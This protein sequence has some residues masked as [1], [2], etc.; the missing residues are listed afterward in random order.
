M[1]SKRKRQSGHEGRK[2]KAQKQ[3]QAA[4]GQCMQLTQLFKNRENAQSESFAIVDLLRCIDENGDRDADTEELRMSGK[5]IAAVIGAQVEKLRLDKSK[6]VG[7][8]YDGA[9]AMS[10]EEVGTAAYFREDAP[11]AQFYHCKSHCLNLSASKSL[12]VPEL[13]SAQ[14]AIKKTVSFFNHSAKRTELLKRHILTSENHD[15]RKKSLMKLCTTRFVDRYRAILCFKEML[16][17]IMSATEKMLLW[18]DGE[19]R[20]AASVIRKLLMDFDFIVGLNILLSMST[21]LLHLSASLQGIGQDTNSALADIQACQKHFQEQR[22]G[23]E[24]SF[25]M[26]YGDSKNLA[27]TLGVEE[28]QPR[29]AG[30]SNYRANAPAVSAEAYYRKI[31][32]E[33]TD[34]SN[35]NRSAHTKCRGAYDF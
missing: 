33:K 9:S 21:R 34:D 11:L 1:E 5:N 15:L 28:K 4:A 17:F 24:A 10:S 2:K 8:G 27:E 16:S 35:D 18:G 6:C 23:S 19:T 20:R 25:A 30:R 13:D 14:S 32:T 22:D 31:I 29:V 3:M 26:I 7:Q 12:K